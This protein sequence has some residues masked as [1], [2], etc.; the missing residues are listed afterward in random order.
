MEFRN[1]GRSGLKISEI[2]FGNW[3]THGLQVDDPTAHA[4]IRAALD[5]AMMTFDKAAG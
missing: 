5:A 2:T 3:I 1:L 4:T